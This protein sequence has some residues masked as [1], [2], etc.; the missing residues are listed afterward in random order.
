[1]TVEALTD[2][3]A[4]KANTATEKEEMLRRESFPPNYNDQ[5]YVLG[6]PA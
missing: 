1:M 5:Y 3:E 6:P 2:R 4:K